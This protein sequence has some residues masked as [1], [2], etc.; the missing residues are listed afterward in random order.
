MTEEMKFRSNLTVADM[1]AV[2]LCLREPNARACG[3][4]DCSA[5]KVDL[6]FRTAQREH[7]SAP[8][9]SEPLTII[10]SAGALMLCGAP[11]RK[12]LRVVCVVGRYRGV[13]RHPPIEFVVQ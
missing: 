7:D 2:F 12:L 8:S 5:R 6:F 4:H 1:V 13:L 3:S 11:A 9:R 10:R